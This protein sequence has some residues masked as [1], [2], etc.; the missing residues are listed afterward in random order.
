MPKHQGMSH[1]RC[2]EPPA[3]PKRTKGLRFREGLLSAVQG[4]GHETMLPRGAAKAHDLH[5][6]A[7]QRASGIRRCPRLAS[8]RRTSLRLGFD[9]VAPA[10]YR[11]VPNHVGL[12]PGAN[13]RLRRAPGPGASLLPGTHPSDTSSR[14]RP[15]V[16]DRRRAF[17]QPSTIHQ[18][19]F[20]GNDFPGFHPGSARHIQPAVVSRGRDVQRN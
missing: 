14:P 18:S 15:P 13:S 19:R 17:A 16:R 6:D 3:A 2:L 5:L 8:G 7:V 11:N 12:Q 20:R 1:S 10:T 9:A 4:F